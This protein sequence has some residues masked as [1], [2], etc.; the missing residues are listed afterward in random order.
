MHDSYCLYSLSHSAMVEISVMLIDTILLCLKNLLTDSGS[1]KYSSKI[2]DT[3][4]IHTTY[5]L[6][7]I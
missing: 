1:N 5:I 4:H 2:E 6:L 7:Q 3:R